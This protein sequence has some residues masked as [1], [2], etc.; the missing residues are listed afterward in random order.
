[1][2]PQE[3]SYQTSFPSLES[4]GS[5]PSP[6]IVGP[7][8]KKLTT[9]NG[10]NGTNSNA[11]PDDTWDAVGGGVEP[12]VA[13]LTS[14]E[15]EDCFK[16]A[17][18]SFDDMNLSDPI[19]RGV[20]GYGFE[21]PSVV[22]QIAIP[23]M[24][25][26][27]DL[28]AQA[29]SGTG[30]TGAFTVGTLGLIDNKLSKTQ[31]IM[32][33][34]T[35]ELASQT[36]E[37]VQ[38]IGWHLDLGIHCCVGGR[39]VAEDAQVLRKGCQVVVG[40]PGR[41]L[42]LIQRRILSTHH[43]KVLVVD[44]AD[45]M[46]SRG[47]RD[48]LFDIVQALPP[49][50]QICL[51]S[52]TMPDEMLEVTS[53]VC[54]NPFKVILPKEEIT[55]AGIKQ[56]FVDCVEDR[57]KLP[58]LLDLYENLAISQAII[59]CNSRRTVEWLSS[60]LNENQFT[61]RALHAGVSHSERAEI[62]KHF[63]G[64]HSRVLVSSDLTARGIDVQS[65]SLVINFELPVEHANYIHRIGR[66]GRFG[67]QG[68]AINLITKATMRDLRVIEEFYHTHIEPLPQDLRILLPSY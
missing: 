13:P 29:Q 46:L 58:T 39:S 54:R 61:V 4:R 17:C 27:R 10:H 38:N 9:A 12:P 7:N 2:Q 33:A 63:R 15:H 44:E 49:D 68:V 32:L 45:E 43:V 47:F 60:K 48:Q 52:A 23:V 30:K 42:D 62:M 67:R 35:R 21:R 24:L 53:K 31:V 55:L 64:G 36:F 59:F 8:P 25:T 37:V 14:R 20:Y 57:D 19:L 5:S 18:N 56:Y 51:F 26:K 34:P 3:T 6:R 50:F 1:M 28:I 41:L 11:D 66:S 22:Q 65:V 16:L 40:T